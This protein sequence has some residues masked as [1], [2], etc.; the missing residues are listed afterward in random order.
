MNKLKI[1]TNKNS[2]DIKK[3]LQ[4]KNKEI[5]QK[6]L[7]YCNFQAVLINQDK[8]QIH[9]KEKTKLVYNDNDK[10]IQ[11]NYSRIVT[12]PEE[13]DEDMDSIILRLNFNTIDIHN[14]NIFKEGNIF[15]KKFKNKFKNDIEGFLFPQTR[16]VAYIYNRNL[17]NSIMK[18]SNSNNK[19]YST[20][21]TSSKK[22]VSRVYNK[23]QIGE[24]SIEK[25][26][27]NLFNIHLS[28]I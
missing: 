7:K 12:S 2:I 27:V 16:Y 24:I 5:I 9:N 26:R 13:D 10:I 14:D 21:D 15:Y 22:N 17:I 25:E 20:M 1:L 19:S 6:D 28:K 23:M 11:N 3:K 8:E 18:G 4:D